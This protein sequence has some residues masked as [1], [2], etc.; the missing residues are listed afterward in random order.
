MWVLVVICVALTFAVAIAAQ[1]H[2]F[3]LNITQL[4]TFKRLTNDDG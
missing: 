4:I 1:L 3:N 2:L